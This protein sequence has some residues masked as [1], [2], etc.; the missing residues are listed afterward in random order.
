M[1][2][3]ADIQNLLNFS[4]VPAFAGTTEKVIFRYSLIPALDA[5]F[6]QGRHLALGALLGGLPGSLRAGMRCRLM[7]PVR[8][9]VATV[10]VAGVFRST[11]VAVHLR[12][13]GI[14]IAM[15]LG[16]RTRMRLRMRML[17]GG[18][19]MW[20]RIRMRTLGTGTSV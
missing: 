10:I 3:E 15:I 1:P 14:S 18:A 6:E 19:G 20:I 11:P 8:R 7:R 13:R 17:A 12:A 4:G 9:I 5:A 16:G 2:A